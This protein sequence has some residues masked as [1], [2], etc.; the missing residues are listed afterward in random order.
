MGQGPS[1]CATLSNA[2]R[3]CFL[4]GLPSQQ[5]EPIVS[6]RMNPT[7]LVIFSFTF[8]PVRV[9]VAPQARLYPSRKGIR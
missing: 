7:A 3:F 6:H 1:C 5:T 8:V 4:A 2:D 9:F